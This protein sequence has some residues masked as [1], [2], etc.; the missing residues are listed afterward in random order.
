MAR[1]YFRHDGEAPSPDAPSLECSFADAANALR[2]RPGDLLPIPKGSV[3]R[4]GERTQLSLIAGP[5]H[6]YVHLGED[7]EAPPYKPFAHRA[8]FP[9]RAG[10]YRAGMHPREAKQALGLA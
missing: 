8:A 9:W 1:V 10:W 7:E 2:L 3:P 4:T 5:A 6:V